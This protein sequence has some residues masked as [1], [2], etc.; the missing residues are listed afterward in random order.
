MTGWLSQ[1]P[2]NTSSVGSTTSC[3]QKSQVLLP[4]QRGD[5]QIQNICIPLNKAVM[6]W[7]SMQHLLTEE[8]VAAGNSGDQLYKYIQKTLIK[9]PRTDPLGLWST[10]TQGTSSLNHCQDLEKYTKGCTSTRDT[11]APASWH[12][13]RRHIGPNEALLWLRA[14][15]RLWFSE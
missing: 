1:I 8:P 4:E 11:S 12:C 2:W 7:C 5:N 3:P 13:R 6:Y 14:E 10:V 9:C 15:P